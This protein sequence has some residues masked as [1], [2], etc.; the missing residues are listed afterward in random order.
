MKNI[1]AKIPGT[2]P[3]ILL[4]AAHYDTVRLPNFVGA[5]DGGSGTG[6][7]LELARLLCSRKSKRCGEKN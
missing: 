5:D 4:F 7:M 6:A 2:G 3:D 1:I